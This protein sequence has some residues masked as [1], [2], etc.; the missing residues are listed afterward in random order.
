MQ[1]VEEFFDQQKPFYFLQYA[2]LEKRFK[3]FLKEREVAENLC[4]YLKQLANFKS[5]TTVRDFMNSIEEAQQ[6]RSTAARKEKVCTVTLRLVGEWLEKTMD[7]LEKLVNELFKEKTYVL[8]H[9]KIVRGSIVVTYLA[10]L[11][12]ADSLI[13]IAKTTTEHFMFEVGISGLEIGSW[14]TNFRMPKTVSFGS[15]L[16]TAVSDDNISFLLSINT[17]PNAADQSNQTALHV[18][19]ELNHDKSMI[20]LLQAN[21]NPNL[22]DNKGRTPLF[23][24]SENGHTD[25]VAIL[26]K[27][28]ANTDLQETEGCTPL[29]IASQNGH[30]DVA[31]IL[32]KN[33][34]NP[35]LQG[36]K[37]CTPLYIAT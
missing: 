33:K 5:S 16:L 31:A 3:Y 37:G 18:A 4:D 32:L 1:T 12:E 9:L 15:S 36:T 7:D 25:V 27:H 22:Q 29:Y 6:S 30:T 19:S 28:N 20:L 21:P 10:P 24:A 26:L 8:S 14:I 23:I 35:D 11:S 13:V 34:A 17:N 2:L